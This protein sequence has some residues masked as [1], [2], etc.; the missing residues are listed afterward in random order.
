MG[1]ET[2]LE[3]E[4]LFQVWQCNKGTMQLAKAAL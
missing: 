1:E 2:I 4:L 3:E